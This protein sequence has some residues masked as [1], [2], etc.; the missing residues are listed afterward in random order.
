MTA[1]DNRLHSLNETAGL[2]WELAQKPVSVEEIEAV[3][4]E[5]YEVGDANVRDDL[6]E[7]I[8]QLVERAILEWVKS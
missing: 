4:R 6:S 1:S 3:L 2:I 5:S 8:D 7:I